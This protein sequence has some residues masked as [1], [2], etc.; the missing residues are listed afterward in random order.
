MSVISDF[1]QPDS[2][3]E[4]FIEFLDF[5]DRH[6]A[7]RAARADTLERM[8]LMPGDKVLDVGCGLGGVTFPLAKITGPAGL[9]AGIDIKPA[10]IETANH[11]AAGRPGVEFRVGDAGSIPYPDD[12]FA[13]AHS[14]RVFLYLTDRLAAIEEMKRVVR[15]G[16]RV[17]L[18]DADADSMAIYSTDY[19]LTRKMLA[20][21]A[22]TLPNPYSA[23]ELPI[24]LRRAGLRDATTDVFAISAPHEVLTRAFT[25]T[26]MKAVESGE[27]SHAEVDDWLGEQAALNASGDFFCTWLMTRC[28]GT[29]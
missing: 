3:P 27:L 2:A 15:P 6:A 11:R 18:L 20:V 9:V 10:F 19:P 29:V 1:T 22:A 24:L 26:L 13:A 25:A 7:I 4:F 21:L 8:A 17:W 5:M 23:R 28:S 12:F 14:E 16:G